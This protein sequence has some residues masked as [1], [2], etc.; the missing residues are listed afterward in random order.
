MTVTK[1]EKIYNW[2]IKPLEPYLKESQDIKTLVF[3][4]DGKLRNIPTLQLMV[5]FYTEFKKGGVSKAK[6]LHRA[7]AYMTKPY[8]E[9]EFIATVDG[10]MDNQVNGLTHVF[11]KG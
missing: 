6:T 3:A 10:L 7:T 11:V 5:H 1:S 8:L 4:L 2:L 9:H